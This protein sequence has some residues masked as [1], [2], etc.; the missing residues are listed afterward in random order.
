MR[1]TGN[2]FKLNAYLR[3]PCDVVAAGVLTVWGLSF[4]GHV[5]SADVP[6]GIVQ[7]ALVAMHLVMIGF[8][9]MFVAYMKEERGRG[10]EREEDDDGGEVELVGK[11][12]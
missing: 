8:G 10:R 9:A 11:S 4:L 7:F 3:I 12:V 1:P 2:H 5:K 6:V